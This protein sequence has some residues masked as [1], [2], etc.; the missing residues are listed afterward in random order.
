MGIMDGLVSRMDPATLIESYLRS[1][2]W[3]ACR[4]DFDTSSATLS[5]SVLIDNQVKSIP[6]PL[7]QIFTVDRIVEMISRGDP[8]R[9]DSCSSPP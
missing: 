6:L 9:P 8:N 7:G 4:L 5:L 2:G 3:Q 1:N